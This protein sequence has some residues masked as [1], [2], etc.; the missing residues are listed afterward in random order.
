[1]HYFLKKLFLYSPEAWIRQI[2]CIV[3]G[4]QG[5]IYHC[6]FNDPWAEVFMLGHRGRGQKGTVKMMYNFDD[7]LYQ[8]TV[9]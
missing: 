1:M 6:K 7:I 3:N 4:D 9:Y 5:R 8:Y 2:K